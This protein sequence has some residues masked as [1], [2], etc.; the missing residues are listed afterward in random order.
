MLNLHLS[1]SWNLT[2]PCDYGGAVTN[3]LFMHTGTAMYLRHNSHP[4]YLTNAKNV[5]DVSTNASCM[6]SSFLDLE[7]A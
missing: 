1:P 2:T 6:N 3:A 5:S 7:L 4:E